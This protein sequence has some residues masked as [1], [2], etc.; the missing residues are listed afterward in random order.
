MY[1]GVLFVENIGRAGIRFCTR[2]ID[3]HRFRG[4]ADFRIGENM[5]FRGRNLLLLVVLAGSLLADVQSVVM[6]TDA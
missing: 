5:H 2:T 1:G 4:D 6:P 3:E